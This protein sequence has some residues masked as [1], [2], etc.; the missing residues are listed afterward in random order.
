MYL[1]L[2]RYNSYCCPGKTLLAPLFF[3]S[4]PRCRSI[5][6]AMA[7]VII[8]IPKPLSWVPC[9]STATT[10]RAAIPDFP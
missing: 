7:Q 5:V 6:L 3:W 9:P 1:Q 4:C 2:N 8:I 10:F